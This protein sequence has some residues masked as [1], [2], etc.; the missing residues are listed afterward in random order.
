MSSGICYQLNC[1]LCIHTYIH[2]YTALAQ[3]DFNP[4]VKTKTFKIWLTLQKTESFAFGPHQAK[5]FAT[6]IS[7]LGSIRTSQHITSPKILHNIIK[8]TVNLQYLSL[9]VRSR[10]CGGRDVYSKDGMLSCCGRVRG[11]LLLSWSAIAKLA[12]WQLVKTLLASRVLISMHQNA[13]ML[14]NAFSALPLLSTN[15]LP[16][17]TLCQDAIWIMGT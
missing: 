11:R 5:G 6:Y 15:L 8:H 1:Y 13:N 4:T 3:N 7:R 2:L 14:R 16:S 17:K 10:L 12:K 9:P